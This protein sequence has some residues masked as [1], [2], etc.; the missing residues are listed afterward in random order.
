MAQFRKLL[1]KKVTCQKST[2]TS[3]QGK[4]SKFVQYFDSLVT[5]S[6]VYGIQKNIGNG[7]GRDHS[8]HAYSLKRIAPA[9]W[10]NVGELACH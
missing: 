2:I 8:N 5:H 6:F 9:N 10:L 1:S 7:S 4:R 3:V